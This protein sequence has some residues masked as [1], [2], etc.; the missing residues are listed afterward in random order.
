[1]C[2]YKMYTYKFIQ[3][4]SSYTSI[5]LFLF[6]YHHIHI[7]TI[8]KHLKLLDFQ[9]RIYGEQPN[10]T[11][12]TIRIIVETT[13]SSCLTSDSL[14]RNISFKF[15]GLSRSVRVLLL[16]LPQASLTTDR[17]TENKQLS[18]SNSLSFIFLFNI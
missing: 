8:A 15:H 12:I 2:I 10:Q 14:R 3:S 9:I 17:Q 7:F 6:P 16:L 11:W 4:M 13:Y 18:S 1:M 5:C